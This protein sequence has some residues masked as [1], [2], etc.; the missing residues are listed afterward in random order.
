MSCATL[1]LAVMA[2]AALVQ[3]LVTEQRLEL[4][5]AHYLY[6]DGV[7]AVMLGQILRLPVV[8]TRARH[9]REPDPGPRDPAL[10][11][12]AGG[13][14]RART[15]GGGAALRPA[16]LQLGAAEQDVRHAAQRRRPGATC[17]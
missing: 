4:I 8:M 15:G 9:G 10:L 3:R 5:D 16:L 12:R 11:A 6:P 2:C 1:T 14:R 13:A 17:R 7:A